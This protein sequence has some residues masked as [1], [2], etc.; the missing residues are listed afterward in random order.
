MTICYIKP[1]VNFLVRNTVLYIVTVVNES[2][3]AALKANRNIIKTVTIDIAYSGNPVTGIIG[4]VTAALS[5][6]QLKG[7]ERIGRK[8]KQNENEDTIGIWLAE[9]Q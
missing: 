5:E 2:R 1:A 4:S 8:D 7:I 9:I 3:I 6:N